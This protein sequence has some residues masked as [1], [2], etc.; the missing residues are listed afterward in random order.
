MGSMMKATLVTAAALMLAIPASA[1]SVYEWVTDDGVYSYADT[2][3]RVPKRYQSQAK[4][5]TLGSLASYERWTPSDPKAA[6]S[7]A[8][9]LEGNLARLRDLNAALDP[10]DALGTRAGV[11]MQLRLGANGDAIS[12]PT[13][14]TGPVVVEEI[15]TRFP[16]ENATR[17][18]TLVR[19][20]DEI[21]AT[22]VGQRN[23]GP[24]VQVPSDDLLET[25]S[26]RPV[27]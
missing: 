21:V 9:R 12:V 19:Q 13:A 10:M 25:L 20:G 17:T 22:L 15:R 7:Y 4:K 26:E 2:L 11:R 1:G 14:S 16:G 23:D 5:R 24:I 27:Y 3:K 8:G 18:V 6:D